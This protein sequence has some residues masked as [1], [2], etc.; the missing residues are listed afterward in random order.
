MRPELIANCIHAE[1]LKGRAMQQDQN[2]GGHRQ[3]HMR[4]P[5]AALYLSLSVSKLAKLRM[6]HSGE[7]GPRYAKLSGVVI[8]RRPDLDNWLAANMMGGNDE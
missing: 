5:E 6:R 4:P 7:D 2:D 8:Y 3:D 1:Q